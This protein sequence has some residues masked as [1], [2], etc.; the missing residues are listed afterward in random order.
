MTQVS[1][2]GLHHVTAIATDPQ[3]NVDF[4]TRALGLRL[5]KQTVNFDAPDTY[6]LYYGDEKGSPSSLLTFFPWP[7]VPQGR[8]GAGMT[9]ASTAEASVRLHSSPPSATGLSRKSP[10][11]A[12]S[13]RVRMNAAQN[14]ATWLTRVLK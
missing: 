1:P 13:G 6:H 10:T 8:Q 14:S 3:A 11:V 5:V 9:T 2:Q 4:Y 12:P 7:G